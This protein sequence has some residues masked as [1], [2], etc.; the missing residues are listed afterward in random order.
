MFHSI[1][2]LWVFSKGFLIFAKIST[3]R[4]IIMPITEQEL[5]FLMMNKITKF[6]VELVKQKILKSF[7]L[8]SINKIFLLE[9]AS[10]I[11]LSATQEKPIKMI[12]L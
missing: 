4:S 1:G 11:S 2:L 8:L 6:W 12:L 7:F 3:L 5:N 10:F 9:A